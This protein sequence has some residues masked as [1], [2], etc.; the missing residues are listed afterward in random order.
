MFPHH[1]LSFFNSW[2]VLI[3]RINRRHCHEDIFDLI[4]GRGFVSN[5]FHINSYFIYL[6]IATK[7]S[8]LKVLIWIEVWFQYLFSSSSS[9]DNEIHRENSCEFSIQNDRVTL[10][11]IRQLQHYPMMILFHKFE[12]NLYSMQIL[13]LSMLIC[14]RRLSWENEKS[15][16]DNFWSHSNVIHEADS[17]IKIVEWW[18]ER[19][20]W[21][22]RSDHMISYHSSCHRHWH[23]TKSAK[24]NAISNVRGTYLIWN[25][26]GLFSFSRI[27]WLW[28]AN[29]VFRTSTTVSV[30]FV[31]QCTVSRWSQFRWFTHLKPIFKWFFF[32]RDNM[33]WMR[34]RSRLR[35]IT[36][37]VN[38]FDMK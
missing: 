7:H 37:A 10:I 30:N 21:N 28:I 24:Q 27:R 5:K 23:L 20:Q 12:R 32:R 38:N 34:V 16:N 36:S 8:N 22:F 26:R 11:V 25:D 14:C 6:F 33:I 9:S 31:I 29:P 3:L 15:F 13:K 35:L 4:W 2:I 19:N 18:F 17:G 1:K